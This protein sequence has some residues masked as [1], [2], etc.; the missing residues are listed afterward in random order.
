MAGDGDALRREATRELHRML[1]K[2]ATFRDGQWEA[3]ERLL[4]ARRNLLLV[5]PT[6]WGK[7]LVYFVA[8]RLFRRRGAGPT[9][10]VSPLL[11]LMR[12][13][14]AMAKRMG[15]KAGTL[16]SAN[17]AEWRA[18]ERLLADGRCDLLLIA[19]ERLASRRFRDEVLPRLQRDLGLLVVDEAHCISEWGHDFRPDY[20]RVGPLV[21]SLP[22]GIPL[23][24]T[25]AT[26][27]RRVV[28][29]IRDQ[30]AVALDVVRG[31]L[32]R[33]SLHLQVVPL[34]SRTERLAWLADNLP[35][36][37]GS[38]VVYC[39]T[40]ADC[41]WVSRWLATR[42][43]DAPAY[44]AEL[45]AEERPR[46]EHSLQANEVKA[47]VATVALGMGF[48]K[49]DLGFVVHFQRPG[50][51]V[52]YYQQIGRAGRALPQ[53]PVVLL[54]GAEDDAISGFFIDHAFPEPHQT[55]A[56]LATIGRER[57]IGF[58][59]LLAQVNLPEAKLEQC[60]KLLAVEGAVLRDHDGGYHPAGPWSPDPRMTALVT[61]TRRRELERM[62]ELCRTR[63]CLMQ[64][65]LRELDDPSAS[66]C[67]RC[68]NCA[69]PAWPR[70]VRAASARRARRFLRRSRLPIT[71]KTTWPEGP[72]D[73]LEG[74]IPEE[75]RNREGRAL[76]LCGREGLGGLVE[77][78]R[79]AE[80]RFPPALARQA[81][82][83][84]R[85]EWSPSPTP[86]WLTCIP[87]ARRPEL[88]PAF[89]TALARRLGIPFR[90][91]LARTLV[92]PPQNAQRNAVTRVRGACA[93]LSVK[94]EEVLPGPVLLV[95]DL[96][97]SG[98]TLTVA[99]FSLREAGAGPVLPFALTMAA[100]T[101]AWR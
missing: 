19:P 73:G 18:T 7:S 72:L 88:V 101:R 29:D 58:G 53:A 23:L 74:E 96:V 52:A 59:D 4:I 91:A 5:Q 89:A 92:G 16:H 20:R 56:V 2:A 55:E 8:T 87:S 38:G 42:G 84:I 50:S 69:G 71:A 83:Y 99:G 60:L 57:A 39:L 100:S 45:P 9:V 36:L 86:A 61:A 27:A 3:V 70:R 31:P 94:P 33:S 44:H 51:A 13:Q 78:A 98:W 62:R 85:R 43:I 22:A 15:L 30:L 68:A 6:G 46:L 41:E 25:T 75:L 21:R 90:P 82:R 47:L 80:H 28:E 77:R 26:A 76:C 81:A 11:S 66:P 32:D 63:A 97:D 93:G 10:L 34:A 67:G 1:G 64:F 37:P 49:P 40:V 24:A 65:V 95:D 12:D 79:H 35:R 17:R 14:V 48:D 54:T